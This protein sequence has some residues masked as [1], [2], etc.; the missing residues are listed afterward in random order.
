[1]A[2]RKDRLH[3]NGYSVIQNSDYFCYG[4]DAVLLAD[5]AVKNSR[6]SERSEDESR[7]NLPLSVF[8]LGTGNAVIPVLLCASSSH[9]IKVTGLEIQEKIADMA[10]RTVKLNSLEKSVRIVRG[11][12]C[13]CD[14]LF[15]ERTADIVVSNPPYMIYGKGRVSS[16]I[17][18]M[19]ARQELLC[20][21]KDVVSSAR[22]LLSDDGEFFMIHRAERHE[23]IL[24]ELEAAGFKS[25]CFRKVKPFSDKKPSMVLYHSRIDE[26]INITELP[27]LTVYESQGVYTP[28]VKKIYGKE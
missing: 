16:N 28:E 11:D 2:E 15:P 23:E 10:E 5:F 19:N 25:V 24:S 14:R 18:K 7:K 13:G 8:D 9:P 4:I 1:M 21:L 20:T 27:P 17:E 6:L 12:I 3:I 26:N 22:Y